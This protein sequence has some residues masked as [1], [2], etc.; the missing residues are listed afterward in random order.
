MSDRAAEL[1]DQV[2]NG[3]RGAQVLF[4]A[5]EL[6]LFAALGRQKLSAS[7]LS[8][9]LGLD[10]RGTRIVCD[11]LVAL[12]LLR[13]LA[14]RYANTAWAQ[15]LLLPDAV[16]S[17]HGLLLHGA[18]LY[19]RWASL[20]EVLRTGRPVPHRTD[21]RA[22]AAAMASSA[23]LG[24][25]ETAAAVDLS[26]AR[27]MLDI[28]GGP[29]LYGIAFARRWPGL[30]VV[31]F[32]QPETAAVAHDYIAQAGLQSRVS[33]RA[34]DAFRDDLG[35]GFDFVLLSNVV[36]SYSA[37]ENQKLIRRAARAL[38][39]GGRLGVKDFILTPGRTGPVWA[40]LFAVNMLI[41]TPGG[42]CYTAAEIRA[43]FRAAGLRPAGMVRLRASSHLLLA[44]RPRAPRG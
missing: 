12:G 34:G 26:G 14:G 7:Q 40:S 4:T 38:A 32:D 30:R 27:S 10:P 42:D 21:A 11:A 18:L 17:Q 28:G 20:P 29:G 31:V 41:N 3:Y 1:L 37:A 39:P 24:A 22:F 25:A 15:R 16:Q 8:R 6:G 9:R 19:R 33:V 44:R 13:K 36:H 35:R 5:A 23:A 2:A 43:W